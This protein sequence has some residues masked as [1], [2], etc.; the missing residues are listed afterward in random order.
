MYGEHSTD[1]R[2]TREGRATVSE[3][4]HDVHQRVTYRGS[5]WTPAAQRKQGEAEGGDLTECCHTT[6]ADGD[7]R[8]R[9]PDASSEGALAFFHKRVRRGD[10][11][12]GYNKKDS[13]RRL[14]RRLVV[15]GG[16]NI[17]TSGW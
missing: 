17:V 13:A 2:F 15:K 4:Y 7:R 9:E 6:S 12:Y 1:P 16:G 14:A 8:T 5:E 3:M 11:V 10:D